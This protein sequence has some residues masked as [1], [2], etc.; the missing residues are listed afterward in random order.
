MR[1][2]TANAAGQSLFSG[3]LP[4]LAFNLPLVS[5]IY[6]TAQ[7]SDSAWLAWLATAVTYPLN[8]LKV[9]QQTALPQHY[10]SPSYRG[11]VP[12]LLLNYFFAHQVTALYSPQRLES[13]KTEVINESIEKLG[14][15]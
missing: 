1:H 15:A 5:A 2:A 7:E 14:Y 9:I 12:F 10:A 4:K 3:I 11:V 6:L 8:T 13:L